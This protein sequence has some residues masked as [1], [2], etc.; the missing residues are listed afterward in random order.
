MR[1]SDPRPCKEELSAAMTNRNY[2]VEQKQ[3]GRIAHTLLKVST[4]MLRLN[5]PF[6]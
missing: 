5:A 1:L 6:F 3:M 2:I 4:A